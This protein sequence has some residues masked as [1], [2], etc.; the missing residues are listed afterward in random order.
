MLWLDRTGKTVGT[1]GAAA[2]ILSL[3]LSPDERQ[4]AVTLVTGSA[5]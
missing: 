3:A 1:L 5:G 4:V 2:A